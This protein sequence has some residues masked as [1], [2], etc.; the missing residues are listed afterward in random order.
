ML[1]AATALLTPTPAAAGR[2][3]K[4]LVVQGSNKKGAFMARMVELLEQLNNHQETHTVI[5]NQLLHSSNTVAA[6]LATV[7][8]RETLSTTEVGSGTRFP[9]FRLQSCSMQ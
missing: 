4:V 2:H 9:R 3:H 5:L 1:A 7:L 8:T 6:H